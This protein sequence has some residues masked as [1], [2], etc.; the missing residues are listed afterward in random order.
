MLLIYLPSNGIAI[1]VS[2][3]LRSSYICWV[4]ANIAKYLYSLG[5]GE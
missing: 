5:V 3:K 4:S 2:I 1:S